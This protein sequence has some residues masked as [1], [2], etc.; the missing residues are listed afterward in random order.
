MH[1]FKKMK[2]VSMLTVLVM[3]FGLISFAAPQAASASSPSFS[4]LNSLSSV[5]FYL[6]R[7]TAGLSKVTA[8]LAALQSLTPSTSLE[9]QLFGP[10]GLLPLPSAVISKYS[11]PSA[12]EA[13]ATQFLIDLEKIKYSPDVSTAM[14]N[15]LTFYSNDATAEGNLLP[16]VSVGDFLAFATNVQTTGL[17]N[18]LGSSS[19]YQT[20]TLSSQSSPLAASFISTALTSAMSNS[21]DTAMANAVS[22]NGWSF[23]N[24]AAAEMLIDQQVDPTYLG[25]TALFEAYVDSNTPINQSTTPVNITV[26]AGGSGSID[27]NSLPT[28]DTGS[29]PAIT[30]NSTV[31]G[32]TSTVTFQQGTTTTASGGTWDGTISL[33]TVVTPTASELPANTNAGSVV[34]ISIGSD[35]G[36]SLTFSKPVSI[37]LPGQTGKSVGYIK[38]GTFTQI[39]NKLTS[40]VLPSG[41]VDGYYDDG[42]NITIWTTHFTTFVAYTLTVVPVTGGGGP[43]GGNG[44]GGPAPAVTTPTPVTTPITPPTPVKGAIFT[45]VPA[46]FWA[47]T[48]IATLSGL[49]Y[50]SGY[51]DGTFMPNNPITRAEFCAVMDKVLNLTTFAQ[52][53]PTFSDVNTG[54]WYYQAVETAVYAGIAN[55]YSDST[56]QPNAPISRQQAAA[57]LVNALGKQNEAKAD[58]GMKTSFTDDTSISS[59]AR[60]Y[61]V[62]AV[63]DALIKGY[64]DGSF[65][66]LNAVTR[67]EACAMI[68]NF[69]TV[70][71]PAT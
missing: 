15:A 44:G 27:L 57:I 21:A 64:S 63:Q 53:T 52:Q 6:A 33:P 19:N 59:W 24:I 43:T 41:V 20:V 35:N 10:S 66:P 11:S 32:A 68:G 71:S 34:A 26:P 49:G 65:G 9:T 36:V 14:A 3:A 31:N 48:D 54:D 28:G 56:F 30:I 5:Y 22:G 12:A 67:A 1:R 47:Y 45:D 38:N 8:D 55:G 18:S 69:L 58:M 42:T 23:A 50:V 51:P 60:G 62:L 39:T 25:E 4:S 29:L 61:V 37:F 40:N 2:L 70:Y 16:G 46:S 7:D 13:A 17:A